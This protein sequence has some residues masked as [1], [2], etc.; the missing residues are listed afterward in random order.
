LINETQCTLPYEL[1]I[2]YALSL[3]NAG[4]AQHISL[5]GFDGYDR[6]D[7]RQIRMNEL[8]DL[9]NHQLLVSVVTLTPATYD[10]AQSSIYATR[11]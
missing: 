8:L 10:L 11:V 5:V 6:D 1:S 7:I 3:A 2:G 4:G 9:Y